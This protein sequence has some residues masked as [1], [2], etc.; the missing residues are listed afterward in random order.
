MSSTIFLSGDEQE[1][2]A[3]II[4]KNSY[5]ITMDK[6]LSEFE[7]GSIVIKDGKIAAIGDNEDIEKRYRAI[8]IIDGTNKLVMPGLINTHTHAAMTMFRGYA[9]DINLQEWLYD[10]IF[11]VEQ[12]FVNAENVALGARLG[13]AEMLR[14]G[15]TTFNDMYYFVDEIAGVV[16]QTGIRAVLSKSLIDFPAPN[17]PTPGEGMDQLKKVIKKW[18]NHSR[19]TIAVGAHSIY[20]C[21]PELIKDSK[22]IADKYSVPFNIHLAE[23]RTE[24]NEIKKEYGLTPLAFLDS[25]GVLSNN[26][27]AAH[28]VHLDPEDIKLMAKKGVRV[29]HNPQCNM[30]IVS[31][32][33]PI[34]QLMDSGVRVGI[35]TDG[36]ASNNDLDMFEEIRTAAFIHKLTCGDP[37]VMDAQTVLKMATNGGAKVLGIEDQTGSLEVGKKAD[38]IILDLEK[39]HA[40]PRY[41]IYSLIVY[42]LKSSDVETVIIDGEIVMKNRNF[43]TIK[44]DVL[45]SEI[46]SLASKISKHIKEF[47]I[48]MN[49][50]KNS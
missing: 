21:D 34:P 9:D 14:G 45:Y 19:I 40:Y 26:V 46:D 36:P 27:I 8:E 35:G 16:D 10:H 18:N 32:V 47:G 30:K 4:I 33:A 7:T 22:L 17:S 49:T 5:I 38:I 2:N 25:L 24:F 15:T 31:G 43:L 48:L 44:E 37:T 1:C 6:S 20:S 11:P 12:K 50:N 41:N 23:T 3:D 28:S 42:S 13:I 39:P 29:A